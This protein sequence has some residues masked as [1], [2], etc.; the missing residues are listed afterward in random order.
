MAKGSYDVLVLGLGAMGSAAAYHLARRGRKVLALD[1]LRPP[2]RQGSS[3]GQ[4]RA[5]RKAYFEDPAYVPLLHRAYDAWRRLAEESGRSLLRRTGTL[6]LGPPDSPVVAG[7]LESAR[8]HGLEHQLLDATE[9]RRRYPVFQP[10]RDTVGVLEE[11][12]GVLAA[13]SS[14]EAHLELA[15]ARGAELRFDEPVESWRELPGQDGVEVVTGRGSYFARH[16][17]LAA[18]A[19]SPD[20]LGSRRRTLSVSRQVLFW[21]SPAGNRDAFEASSLPIWVWA[22]SDGDIFYG[23]PSLE[24]SS[25]GAGTSGV[26]MGI[27]TP[28]ETVSASAV[29]RTV[30]AADLEQLRRCYQGRVEGLSPE[31]IRS[32]VCLYTNS[33]DGHFLL[34]GHPLFPSVTVA[35]GFSGHGFK[36]AALIGEV[37]ADLAIEG[38]TSH[39][40]EVFDPGRFG[41][42][43]E[44][45]AW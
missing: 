13:E 11:V 20:L 24:G 43:A 25:S 1:R 35:A 41:F 10:D 31:P 29:D 9:L 30:S 42:T 44:G 39:A 7:S 37:L 27:H 15:Q 18:G 28:G 14:I 38:T 17:V 26:K 32:C 36:F 3:H 8:E 16:L 34:G 12:G 33:P 40:I 22:P 23:F 6:M 2:H 5:I 45:S 19:W 21:M 4:T